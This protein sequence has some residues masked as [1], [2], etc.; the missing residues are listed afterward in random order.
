ML[1]SAQELLPLTPISPTSLP[2]LS[3]KAKPPPKKLIP[4]LFIMIVANI[5]IEFY[6]FLNT[7]ANSMF[8]F[9]LD[10]F[11]PIEPKPKHSLN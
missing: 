3:Y 10:L 4:H 1:W 9:R 5:K 8:K 6:N 11:K 7:V 2:L